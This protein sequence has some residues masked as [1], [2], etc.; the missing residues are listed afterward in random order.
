MSYKKLVR[1][2]IPEIIK[3]SGSVPI[4]HTL[5]EEGYKQELIKKLGEEV[6][7]FIEKPSLEERADIAEVL[8]ALDVVM[9]FSPEDVET[10]RREKTEERG[11]FNERIYLEGVEE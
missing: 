5:N 9:S 4:F 3:S 1:D 10:A 8:L 11:E 2:K 7:E 6:L